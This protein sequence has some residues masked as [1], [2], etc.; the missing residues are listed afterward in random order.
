MSRKSGTKTESPV[1]RFPF[2]QYASVLG[3]RLL[4]VGFTALYL[5][6]TTRIF[7]PLAARTTDRPQSEFME[8]LT[9]DPSLTLGWISAGLTLLEAWWA[10]WMR[11][12]SFEQRAKGTEVEIKLDRVR[13]D[14]LRFTVRRYELRGR[15]YSL[16]QLVEIEGRD[17]VH[18][19]CGLGNARR[20]RVVWCPTHNVSLFR[21]SFRAIVIESSCSHILQTALLAFVLA[22]LTAFTPAFVLGVL[23][24][25]SDTPSMINRLAWTRLFAEL[26]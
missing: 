20:R 10:S 18:L 6:Q 17:C 11:K 12:W 1:G 9:A 21:P 16:I 4:L 22:I 19:V 3:V 7:A 15:A 14:G 13:F 2:A 26:S 24:L 5:P 25:A 8:A 23:S